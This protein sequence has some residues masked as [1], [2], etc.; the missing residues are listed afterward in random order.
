MSLKSYSRTFLATACVSQRACRISLPEMGVMLLDARLLLVLALLRTSPNNLQAPFR[1]PLANELDTCPISQSVLMLAHPRTGIHG[2]HQAA[3]LRHDKAAAVG[4][5]LCGAGILSIL[6][7]CKHG[8]K[9]AQPI[10]AAYSHHLIMENR[11]I[12]ILCHHEPCCT[13]T[14]IHARQALLVMAHCRQL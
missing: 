6:G 12:F 9:C 14:R 3:G 4:V 13:S 1:G 7:A 2:R 10:N 11:F 5:R 8:G